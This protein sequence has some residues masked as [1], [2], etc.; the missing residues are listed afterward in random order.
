[1][2]ISREA[3]CFERLAQGKKCFFF[4]SSSFSSKRLLLMGHNR[5]GWL[6]ECQSVIF[7]KVNITRSARQSAD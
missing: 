4:L 6:K 2:I 1:M 7:C 3:W 5:F